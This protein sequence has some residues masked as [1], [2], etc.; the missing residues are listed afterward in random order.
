VSAYHTPSQARSLEKF[1]KERG[2]IVKQYEIDERAYIFAKNIEMNSS[3]FTIC[4]MR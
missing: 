4:G 1:L 3:V 2:Y